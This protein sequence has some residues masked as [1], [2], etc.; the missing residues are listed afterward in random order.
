MIVLISVASLTITETMIS[1]FFSSTHASN[2]Q[3][4]SQ[5]YLTYALANLSC[6]S[7]PVVKTPFINKL[8]AT[9]STLLLC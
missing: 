1:S 2:T 6:V 9:S 5:P 8:G 3:S 7:V 4:H